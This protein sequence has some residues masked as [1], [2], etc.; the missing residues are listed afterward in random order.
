MRRSERWTK[1]LGVILLAATV[2]APAVRP[3]LDAAEP[4]TTTRVEREHDPDACVV[5]HDH[6][7]CVQLY[8]SAAAPEPSPV[9]PWTATDHALPGPGREGDP[10]APAPSGRLGARAPPLLPVS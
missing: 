5:H 2:A 4:R 10:R 6:R 8:A 1:V 9:L 3:L 7:A